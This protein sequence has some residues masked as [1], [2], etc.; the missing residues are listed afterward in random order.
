MCAEASTI[1]RAVAADF[2]FTAGIWRSLPITVFG[3]N[4]VSPLSCARLSIGNVL[5]FLCWKWKPYPEL[6]SVSPD[7][8]EVCFMYEKFAACREFGVV[9]TEFCD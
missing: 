8:F 1:L 4:R 5:E 6:Y 7:W 3:T 2:F 9:L